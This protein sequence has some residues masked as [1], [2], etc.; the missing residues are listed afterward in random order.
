MASLDA[1]GMHGTTNIQSSNDPISSSYTGLLQKGHEAQKG[2]V[3]SL[4]SHRYRWLC[5]N[6]VSC[7][8]ACGLLWAASLYCAYACEYHQA[9]VRHMHAWISVSGCGYVWCTCVEKGTTALVLCGSLS[10]FLNHLN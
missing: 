1:K 3:V 10:D 9:G 5:I 4:R 2:C 8:L 7:L 6:S